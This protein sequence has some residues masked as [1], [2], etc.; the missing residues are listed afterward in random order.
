M[1]QFIIFIFEKSRCNDKFVVKSI[2]REC[3]S[4]RC[5]GAWLIPALGAEADRSL[6]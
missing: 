2:V 6:S 5:S 4:A 1:L 3:I